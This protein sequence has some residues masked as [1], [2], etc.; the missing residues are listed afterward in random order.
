[1][2]AVRPGLLDALSQVPDPRDPRGVRYAF[3]SV[4]A[5]AVCA[6]LAGA[7]SFSAIAEWA[8][9]APP[10]V[11]AALGLEPA[12]LG[13]RRHLRRRPLPGPHRQRTPRHGHLA[14]L[15]ISILRLAGHANIAQALRHT[16]RDHTRALQLTMNTG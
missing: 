4:L 7:R 11:R 14:Y 6:T 15:A 3:T 12:P 16:A 10:Q 13:P 1:M 9:D 5:V 2:H 8:G